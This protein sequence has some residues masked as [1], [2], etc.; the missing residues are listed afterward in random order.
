MIA[1]AVA[2]T[3]F[4]FIGIIRGEGLWTEFTP[5]STP[6]TRILAF[7]HGF[8]LTMALLVALSWIAFGKGNFSEFLKIII[9]IWI[10]GVI[11]TLMRHLWIS[12]FIAIVFLIFL[13][14]KEERK[15]LKRLFFHYSF[16][17]AILIIFFGYVAFLFPNLGISKTFLGAA[18]IAG[19]RFASTAQVSA[20]ES[21]NW[22]RNVWR[23]AWDEFKT[24]PFLGIGYGK[25][26]S[27]E[28]GAKYRDFVEVRNIH[29]SLLT[30]FIQMGILGI[31]IF[32]YPIF[33]LLRD[34]LKKLRSASSSHGHQFLI[35]VFSTLL[36]NYLVAFLFQT[37]LETNLLGIFFWI[38]IGGLRVLTNSEQ[39]KS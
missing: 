9:P 16:L 11:G 7:A 10:I 23:S 36:V 5:L 8:F 25:K 19:K 34:S 38:I 13:L 1:G 14:P 6:G 33:V 22:R 30:I 12:I 3:I 28:I 15:R 32:I 4:I 27:V 35:I 21:L 37:Y 31:I 39:I 2:I 17:A 29:N 18:D 20:D 24:T 26:L